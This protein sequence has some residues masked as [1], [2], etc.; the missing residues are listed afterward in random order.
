MHAC[1]YI[2]MHVH[3]YMYIHIKVNRGLIISSVCVYMCVYVCVSCVDLS[4]FVLP[5]LSHFLYIYIYIY[6][7]S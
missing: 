7:E 3:T 5:A 1:A 4:L 2:C 6:R